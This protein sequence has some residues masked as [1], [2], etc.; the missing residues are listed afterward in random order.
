MRMEQHPASS[1]TRVTEHPFFWIHTAHLLWRRGLEKVARTLLVPPFQCG[2]PQSQG[3]PTCGLK[4]HK[5]NSSIKRRPL[6]FASWNVRTLHDTG[7]GA[8]RRTALIASELAR[9]N[10]DI[11]A[12]CNTRLPD[13]VTLMEMGTGCKFSGVAYTKLP[14]TFM[15]LDLQLGL[16]FCR[17]LT[18][19]PLQ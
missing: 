10:I 2:L 5:I 9:Y 12:L 14:V 17:A 16:R 8:Q 15:A 7:L 4:K 19:P 3:Y 1:T 18:N 6:V 13:E 11:A